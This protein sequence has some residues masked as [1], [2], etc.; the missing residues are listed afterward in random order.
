MNIIVSGWPGVGQSSL[1]VIL[2]NALNFKLI[3]GS[4]LF[5]YVGS[6]INFENTGLDRVKADE[7]LEPYLGPLLEK[8]LQWNLLNKDNIVTESDISGF[9]TKDNK[10]IFSIF[11]K[12]SKEVREDRLKVDGR[13]KDIGYIDLRDK[14]LEKS[15]NN[16]FGVD[17]LNEEA[18]DNAYTLPLDTSELTIAQ[19]LKIVYTK[20]KDMGFLKEE[21]FNTLIINLEQEESFF[22]SNG[23]DKYKEILKEKGLL[24][25]AKEIIIEIKEIFSTDVENLPQDIKNTFYSFKAD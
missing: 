14:S 17:F 19:E 1:S 23:K 5:R 11:L 2:A 3:Q 22:W 24:L 12:A 20:L 8:Y 4:A 13:A 10:N 6:E 21:S 25:S 7:Y 16:L 9:F 18:I 15:Y